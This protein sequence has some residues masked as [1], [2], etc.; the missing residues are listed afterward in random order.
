[1]GDL[2]DVINHILIK[3][4]KKKLIRLNDKLSLREDLGFDSLDLAELTVRIED[5]FS[6]DIFE[7]EMVDS[8]K[9]IKRKLKL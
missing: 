2:L 8:I 5:L 3:K 9:D 4:R 1:M 6:I 7:G